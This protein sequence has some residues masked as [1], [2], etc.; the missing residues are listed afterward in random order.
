MAVWRQWLGPDEP[1]RIACSTGPV[2][3]AGAALVD[4]GASALAD[5]NLEALQAVG[6]G[7]NLLR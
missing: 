7:P 2:R 5:L 1:G 3:L 4:Q 6:P